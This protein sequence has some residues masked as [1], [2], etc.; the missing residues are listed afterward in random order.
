MYSP[1]ER[2]VTI[3]AGWQSV[4]DNKTYLY[5]LLLEQEMQSELLSE[6]ERIYSASQAEADGCVGQYESDG[7]SSY[8]HQK[9]GLLKMEMRMATE[10]GMPLALDSLKRVATA[11]RKENYC[12]PLVSLEKRVFIDYEPLKV[13]LPTIY[14][15]RNPIPQTK[16]YERGTIYRIRIG[17]FTNRPNLSALRGITPLSYTTKYHD[18][19]NAYFVGGFSTEKEA[20]EGVAYLKKIGFRDPIVVMWVDGEYI[21]DL[22]KPRDADISFNLEISGIS[23]LSE[24]VKQA[25]SRNGSYNVSRIGGVFVVGAF[26]GRSSAESIAAE[27]SRL[28][29]SAKVAVKELK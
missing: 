10:L 8:Y 19:K 25:L 7:L 11:L 18:G 1:I 6:T 27:V 2:T 29:P 15:S 28:E 26:I 9:N 16:I 23:S 20:R 13:I 24:S 5:N 21:S 12:L 4:S 14:S 17:I 3:V 22:T